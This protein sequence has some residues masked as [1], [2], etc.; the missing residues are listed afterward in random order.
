MSVLRDFR[1]LVLV[2]IYL[3][4]TVIVATVKAS[5]YDLTEAARQGDVVGSFMIL[6]SLADQG[7]AE[8]QFMLGTLYVAGK[9][10]PKDL[11]EAAKW[12]RKA[13]DQGDR[14]AEFALGV[15][16]SR[17]LGVPQ[18]AVQ[19][20][21]WYGKAA[22]EGHAGAEYA[23]ARKYIEGDGVGRD[24]AIA[25]RWSSRAAAQGLAEAQLLLAKM[26]ADGRGVP[27]DNRAGFA[28]AS[29]AESR[30]SD[31]RLRD[32]A[33]RLRRSAAAVLTAEQVTQA[34]HLAAEWRSISE[35]P[36]EK[37]DVA[38]EQDG[39]AASLRVAHGEA[40]VEWHFVGPMPAPLSDVTGTVDNEAL[41]VPHLEPYPYP[42]VTT[43]ILFLLDVTDPNRDTQIQ[44]DKVTLA[45]IASH[46]RAHQQIDIAIYADSLHVLVPDRPDA[47]A[48]VNLA[49]AAPPRASAA[50]LGKV[51]KEAIGLP[52]FYR[53]ERRA[54]FAL[55]DGHSD[56]ALDAENL[57]KNAKRTRTSLNFIVSP[58]ARSV[59]LS[60]LE[61]LA[62][63]TGGVLVRRDQLQEFIRSPFEFVDSGAIARFPLSHL[64]RDLQ[65]DPEIKVVFK[66]GDRML[67]LHS[68]AVNPARTEMQALEQV[69]NSCDIT[70]TDDFKRKIQERSNQLHA[71]EMIYVEAGDSKGR[72]REYVSECSACSFR[73]EAKVRARALAEIS[74]DDKVVQQV[75]VAPRSANLSSPC[76][77]SQSKCTMPLSSAEEQKLKPLDR[78]KE[79]DICPE[80]VVVP[81]GTFTMGSL[82]TEEGH[83]VSGFK[84]YSAE[85]PQHQVTFA[86]P[87]AVGRFALTFDEWD[88]CV[89]EGG[90][91]TSTPISD[92]GWGRGQRPVIGLS[93]IDV[94]E[95]VRWLSRRTGQVY[96]PLSEAEREYATR[97]GTTSPFWWGSSISPQDA[98][99]TPS[100]GSGQQKTLP[101][102]TFAPN[103]WGLFQMH[104]NVSEWVGDCAHGYDAAPSDGSAVVSSEF[105][106]ARMVRGGSWKD[107]AV[108][109]RAA[110]RSWVWSPYDRASDRYGTIGFRVART[111]NPLSR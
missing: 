69:L 81:A 11:S 110:A 24:D 34:Q 101:V 2:S 63:A 108:S 93:Y 103:P 57:T 80:M 77:T 3:A 89:N 9:G 64:R 14:N 88:A 92:H 21:Y 38:R 56:D 65:K 99:Y 31:P 97:A 51:L 70:C 50:N 10:L 78:F 25:A 52:P 73:D 68:S 15:L 32:E 71:E 6:R 96:R 48:L 86:R 18:D 84:N 55:T 107:N 33:S 85:G 19:A 35:R 29:I 42:G 45:D 54:I 100:Q 40:V 76:D 87:F 83:F 61:R 26:S 98:N 46:S 106:D 30:L 72:L 49:K 47:Q 105:C 90:C 27:Q 44:N 111:L 53:A 7:R 104:G 23:L 1:R 82:E 8:A 4:G 36:Q 22:D 66:Y 109:L 16:S 60:S 62:T 12:Y 58:S 37:V 91:S 39:L 20:A 79:C 59:D 74:T 102:A 43:S 17:G 28:W 5:A 75:D 67:E 94:K 13:A 95:Y 41:G